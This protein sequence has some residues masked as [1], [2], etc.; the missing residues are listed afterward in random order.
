MSTI[1]I[2]VTDAVTIISPARR[3]SDRVGL[4]IHG[5][6][7]TTTIRELLVAAREDG[8]ATFCAIASTDR[9]YTFVQPQQTTQ[10]ESGAR[11][12]DG[13]YLGGF[14][15]NTVDA[16]VT[17]G[18]G[19]NR[20]STASTVRLELTAAAADVLAYVAGVTAALTLWVDGTDLTITAELV[21]DGGRTSCHPPE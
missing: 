18:R 9:N 4:T 21:E 17:D 19:R 5:G 14:A 20:G 15:Q 13:G 2:G 11:F 8:A 6:A 3:T 7:L 1:T 16:L 10:P 12:G